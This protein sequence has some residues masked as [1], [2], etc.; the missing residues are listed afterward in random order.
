MI[1]LTQKLYSLHRQ[2]LQRHR[3]PDLDER[4]VHGEGPVQLVPLLVEKGLVGTTG[5]AFLYRRYR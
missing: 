3:G 5:F 1:E 2:G 4:P